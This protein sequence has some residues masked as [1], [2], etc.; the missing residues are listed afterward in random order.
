LHS[1]NWPDI[2]QQLRV[3]LEA[4]GVFV[5][6]G[7]SKE[8]DFDAGIV[9]GL[10][11]GGNVLSRGLTIEGLMVSYFLRT[12]SAYDTL[13]QMGR[14][15][16]YRPG[17][18]DLSRIWMPEDLQRHFADLATVEEEIRVD[19][20]RYAAE[21]LTPLQF[22]VRIRR[23]S[24]LVVTSALKMRNAVAVKVGYSGREVS[25]RVFYRLDAAW[26]NQGWQAGARLMDRIREYRD[27]G[28]QISEDL[29]FR[30]V[31]AADVLAFM[32]EYPV[33][34]DCG[35]FNIKFLTEYIRHS[36]EQQ[37]G[38]LTHWNV[39]VIQ[40]QRQAAGRTEALG[41]TET[42]RLVRRSRLKDEAANNNYAD[43]RALTSEGDAG[44]DL[45]PPAFARLELG[46]EDILQAR[47]TELPGVGLLLLY[48]I[49][50][51]SPA[52]NTAKTKKMAL[53]AATDILAA[54]IVIPGLPQDQ[55][56]GQLLE[57]DYIS[58]DLS[59]I[60]LEEPEEEEFTDTEDGIVVGI[61]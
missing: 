25:T 16:G 21:K 48:P 52:P 26:L 27:T 50:R 33:H 5:E 8:V 14:W 19:I 9:Q 20:R 31:P 10:V 55:Q 35:E 57:H 39:V 1:A 46:R 56:T 18:L 30:G 45:Q 32:D 36:I 15:F 13:M 11:V 49:D 53:D 40:R 43:I 38:R 4:T 61:A 12:A 29:I 17:Y 58:A 37:A 51:D 42:V 54:A 24:T 41:S 47:E 3:A 60:K 28:A 34:V 22:A 23:H 7:I 44:A 59:R 6:N 2:Q